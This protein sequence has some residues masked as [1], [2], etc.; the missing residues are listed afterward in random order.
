MQNN[1]LI[2][3]VNNFLPIPIYRACQSRIQRGVFKLL[4]IF[5]CIPILSLAQEDDKIGTEVVNIVKPYSPSVSDAFKIKE[6]PVLNESESLEKKKVTYSIF[7]VPVASTFTPAKGKATTVK[8]AKPI[9]LYDNYA[10]IGYGNFSNVIA[11]LYSNFKISRTDN[12]G[13][14]LKHN[15]SQGG[16]D[17]IVLDDKFYD[18]NLDGNYT[19]RQKDKTYQINAGVEHQIFNWYGLNTIFDEVS[20]DFL[21]EIDPKQSYLSGYLGASID[22]DDSFFERGSATIRYLGD[23]FESSELMYQFFQNFL[24]LSVLRI[25]ILL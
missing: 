17:G 18:T 21:N 14:Y 12:F 2:I 20:N 22:L 9:K 10:S 8:K 1:S 23:D 25:Q 11:E 24:F 16:I 3:T 6:T 13:L 5:L 15:S 4:L 19:S 7:S